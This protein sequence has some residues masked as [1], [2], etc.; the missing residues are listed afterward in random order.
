MKTKEKL[1][2]QQPIQQLYYT[3]SMMKIVGAKQYF[4]ALVIL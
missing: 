3:A 2:N 1:L 4:Q